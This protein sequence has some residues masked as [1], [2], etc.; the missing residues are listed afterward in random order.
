MNLKAL[1]GHT[2]H[3]TLLLTLPLLKPHP[4]AVT[5]HSPILVPESV[6][7]KLNEAQQISYP[8]FHAAAFPAGGVISKFRVW[9]TAESSGRSFKETS[10][11]HTNITFFGLTPGRFHLFTIQAFNAE[12]VQSGDLCNFPSGDGYSVPSNNSESL[13]TL[14]TPPEAPSEVALVE[15]RGKQLTVYPAG[16]CPHCQCSLS[17]SLVLRSR[18]KRRT[19]TARRSAHTP[20]TQTYL[21]GRSW[22]PE[23]RSS[24][25]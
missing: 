1:R 18:G 20:F 13:Y 3:P 24:W 9:L 8:D 14:Q 21:N 19:R 5:M 7:L 16:S 23:R 4:N 11:D 25:S 12:T 17:P 10:G 2:L 6:S 15:A 22:F